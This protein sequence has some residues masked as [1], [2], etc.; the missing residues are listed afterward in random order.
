MEN[1]C[2]HIIRCAVTPE[3]RN[4]V[5]VRLT[6]CRRMGDMSGV[7]LALAMLTGPCTKKEKK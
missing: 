4:S 3:E 2:N 7:Q 5:N 1:K 6:E